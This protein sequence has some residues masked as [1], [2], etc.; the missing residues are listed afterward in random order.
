MQGQA[1]S[2]AAAVT[3]LALVLSG[4]LAVGCGGGDG[5][6]AADQFIGRWFYEPPDPTV[7]GSTGFTLTCTDPIFSTVFPASAM[8]PFL[9]FSGMTFEHGE[10]TD[11]V[12]T[13]G[14]CNFLSWD[15]NGNSATV[16]NPDP[17]LKGEQ[18]ATPFCVYQ[19]NLADTAGNPVAAAILL[20]PTDSWTFQMLPDRT[21]GGARR[22]QLVG[23]AAATLFADNGTATGAMSTP[24][25]TYAGKDTFYR[26]TQP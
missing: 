2:N 7:L 6:S 10:L 11:L 3:M 22:A 19:F 9:I 16:P 13:A 4:G 26:L 20:K 23:S 12:D 24:D 18:D 14:I 1:R 15:V 25:C 17:H 21:E 5:G 8:T